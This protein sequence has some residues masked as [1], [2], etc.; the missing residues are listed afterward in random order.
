MNHW[1]VI[2]KDQPQMLEVRKQFFSDHVAYLTSQS[3]IFVDGASLSES[4]SADPQ[5]GI[6]IV[7]A[8][9]RDHIVNLIENDPMYRKNLREYQI[10]ATGKTFS[11]ND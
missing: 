10:F 11:I 3:D 4:E 6:W 8:N 7:K 2:F 9:D 5:G 1:I